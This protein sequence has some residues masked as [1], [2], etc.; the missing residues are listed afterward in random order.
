MVS[1]K[2]TGQVPPA[3]SRNPNVAWQGFVSAINVGRRLAKILEV[4]GARF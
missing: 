3:P 4:S 1:H 2:G